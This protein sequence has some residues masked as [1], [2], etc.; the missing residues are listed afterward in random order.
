MLKRVLSL[1]YSLKLIKRESDSNYTFSLCSAIVP[2]ALYGLAIYL[3]VIPFITYS[4]IS[5]ML[6]DLFSGNPLSKINLGSSML[7]VAISITYLLVIS[8]AVALV[9]VRSMLKAVLALKSIKFKMAITSEDTLLNTVNEFIITMTRLN[10]RILESK[11]VPFENYYISVFSYI[12]FIT[13][14]AIFV[15]GLSVPF[16]Y[17]TNYIGYGFSLI[18]YL[19]SILFFIAF[20]YPFISRKFNKLSS[21]TAIYAMCSAMTFKIDLKQTKR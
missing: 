19:Y 20:A 10:Q 18:T 8:W 16:T 3:T 21:S 6:L 12:K 9:A 14:L 5:D 13:I 1:L 7:G 15:V 17:P 2:L 4:S 11:V